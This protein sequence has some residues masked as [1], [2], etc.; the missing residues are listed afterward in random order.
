[1]TFRVHPWRFCFTSLEALHFPEGKSGNVLR[2]AF[3]IIFRRIVCVPECTGPAS[4]NVRDACA[5]ARIF[6]P[7][8]AGRGPS[9]LADSPRPFVFR[10]AH[11]DGRTIRPGER[12]HF[13]LHLFDT[14][15]PAFAHFAQAFAEFG[16][17]GIGPR[18][19]RARLDQVW[20]LDADG[21][22]RWRVPEQSPGP[23]EISLVPDVRSV[24]RLVVRFVTPT[25]LKAGNTIAQR[26]EFRIVIERAR[27]RVST[28]CWLYGEGALDMDF[29]GM[30][31]RA[32][33]VRMTRCNIRHVRAERRSSRTGQSHPLGGFVGEAEYEGDLAE[34]LPLL[35][36]ARW[37]GIGRQTVWGKGA[38]E[39]G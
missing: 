16:N 27:D 5:Y 36:A 7:S 30:S 3:G 19:G 26:P 20:Q 6:E 22:P 23:V 25:E 33:L 13:D 18:R 29:R 10:A 14:R 34:F 17:E 24:E 15:E 37:T 35:H 8:A 21:L 31:E 32:A 2:G 38:F 4:C 11:L 9:G 28:L 12:F 39:L 1:M